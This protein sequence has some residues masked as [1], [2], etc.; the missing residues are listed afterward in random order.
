MERIG[1]ANG[2]ICYHVSMKEFDPKRYLFFRP[3]RTTFLQRALEVAPEAAMSVL[4]AVNWSEPVPVLSTYTLPNSDQVRGSLCY[5]HPLSAVLHTGRLDLFQQALKLAGEAAKNPIYIERPKEYSTPCDWVRSQVLSTAA[6]HGSLEQLK[7]L[8]E[9]MA[10]ND[11]HGMTRVGRGTDR[12]VWVELARYGEQDRPLAHWQ[13]VL[14]LLDEKA[15]QDMGLT[16]GNTTPKPP[17]KWNSLERRWREQTHTAALE[18]AAD[19]GNAR[20][21]EALLSLGHAKV[22]PQALL[23]AWQSDS[24]DLALAMLR[25]P[26]KDWE[27]STFHGV[28]FK[29]TAAALVRTLDGWRRCQKNTHPAFTFTWQDIQMQRKASLDGLEAWLEWVADNKASGKLK[30]SKEHDFDKLPVYLGS[31][32][33]QLDS[34][35]FERVRP[36]LNTIGWTLPRWEECEG[37]FADGATSPY[38]AFRLTQIQALEGEQVV[39]FL[40]AAQQQLARHW[41]ETD[42][43]ETIVHTRDRLFQ[44]L[45]DVKDRP[46]PSAWL[47]VAAEGFA[48]SLPEEQAAR[49][50]GSLM[51]QE[52]PQADS[53][54]PKPRL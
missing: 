43:L 31:A 15:R 32:L 22:T 49:F 25:Y 9:A 45:S 38:Q 5:V 30:E 13:E 20:M 48:S 26:K 52:L 11:T 39:R 1:E 36:I 12:D 17:S 7:T 40:E 2:Y 16:Q 33:A 34:D 3:Q 6:C 8:L 10:G 35:R 28:G 27:T 4:E 47:T 50:M 46:A 53:R 23:G 18:Y 54:K 51:D 41:R 19:N 29:E 24:A 37:L 21:V 44:T 14:R 42:Q